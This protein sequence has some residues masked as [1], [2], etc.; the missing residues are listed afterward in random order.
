MC[1]LVEI[2]LEQ[3]RLRLPCVAAQK[4]LVFF[5]EGR[6]TVVLTLLRYILQSLDP[7]L[8]SSLSCREK[9]TLTVGHNFHSEP[10]YGRY[11]F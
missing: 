4:K 7:Q 2:P 6:V 8:L 9:H 10:F 1:I 3:H 5:P 11:M